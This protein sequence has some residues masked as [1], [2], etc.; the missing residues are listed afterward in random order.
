LWSAWADALGF[1]SELASESMLLSRTHGAR[2]TDTIA[3]TR[4]VGGKFGIQADLP[5]GCYSDD[6]QLRLATS[7]AISSDGFDVEAFARVELTVWPAYAL[8]GGR[9]S[10]AAATN[11]ARPN[12][13]WS[14]NFFSGWKEAGGNGAA[15]RIQPHVWAARDLDRTDYL[16]DVMRNAIVSHGH[17][18]A[19][20][21]AALHAASIA[22][23][24]REG[25]VPSEQ[26]WPRLF[27]DAWAA[28]NSFRSDPELSAFWRPRWEQES[29]RSLEDAWRDTIEEC[30][31][32]LSRVGG[33]VAAI[34]NFDAPNG[35]AAAETSYDEVIDELG[36]RAPESRGSGTAT[37]IA[38]MVLAAALPDDPRS[39]SVLAASAIGTDTDTIATMCAAVVGAATSKPAPEVIQDRQYLSNEAD[40]LTRVGFGRPAPKFAY[41]DILRWTPPHSQLDVV[42]LADGRPA[43]AGLG[44]LTFISEP[45][46][47]R[48]AAWSWA[49]TSF[50]PTVLIKHRAGPVDLPKENWP[51]TRQTKPSREP[52]ESKAESRT[53][54]T[55][56]SPSSQP[57]LFDEDQQDRSSG[58]AVAQGPSSRLSAGFPTGAPLDIDQIV[59][60]L[61]STGFEEEQVGHAVISV[62]RNG[63]LEQLAVLTGTIRSLVATRR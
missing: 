31:E 39:S 62:A 9:A 16:D 52:A 27:D 13:T 22:F 1:I 6:T 7:R 29:K 50:G 63:T 23:A 53:E 55:S 44:W 60:W 3:W 28:F 17:P 18:R 33:R 58:D 47:Q 34:Q 37:V 11:M 38:A 57:A 2:L 19:L 30:S 46:E 25:R 35:R 61:Q 41:P 40:R 49:T 20:V 8:G 15:M 5:A 42:G 51:R 45:Y 21:G 32:M 48:D 4:R 36:L 54:R 10:R 59:D 43:L 12:V 56:K 14:T 26:D 24:L